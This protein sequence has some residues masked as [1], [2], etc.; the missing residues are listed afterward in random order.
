MSTPLPTKPSNGARIATFAGAG[1][2]G[3]LAQCRPT[4]AS[5]LRPLM[6]PASRR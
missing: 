1:V 5:G 2:V 3:L 4:S 6:A